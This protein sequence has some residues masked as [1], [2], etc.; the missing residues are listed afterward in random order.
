MEKRKKLQLQKVE[1]KSFV[2]LLDEDEKKKI[3]GGSEDPTLVVGTTIIRIF[4]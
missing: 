1:V 3:F 4:C 2:T